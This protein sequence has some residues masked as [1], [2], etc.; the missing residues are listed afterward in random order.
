MAAKRAVYLAGKWVGPM[1]GLRAGQTVGQWV[2]M[3][4]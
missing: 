1:V 2:D 3:K 4:V